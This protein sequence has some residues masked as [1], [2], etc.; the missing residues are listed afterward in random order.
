MHY[1]DGGVWQHAD[2]VPP[3]D[4]PAYLSG[5][6][7]A[8]ERSVDFRQWWDAHPEHHRAAWLTTP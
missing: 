1:D 5:I 2:L 4:R 8:L 7:A 6:Q 3:G